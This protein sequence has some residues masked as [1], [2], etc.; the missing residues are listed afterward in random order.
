RITG[1][2]RRRPVSATPFTPLVVPDW[3]DDPDQVLSALAGHT[4][5]EPSA[6]D[7]AGSE[8]VDA[9]IA[10]IGG[11]FIDR[12]LL[13]R[14]L[15]KF[16]EDFDSYLR[17]HFTACT[18]SQRLAESRPR[19]AADTG[20][21]AH[22]AL[23]G[24]ASRQAL[25]GPGSLSVFG[26]GLSMLIRV[27]AAEATTVDFREMRIMAPV[28]GDDRNDLTGG[29]EAIALAEVAEAVESILLSPELFAVCNEIGP[30]V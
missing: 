13:D 26:A 16:D 11:W 5:D 28:A 30:R 3:V 27:A 10:A 22:L 2:V 4:A 17:G 24:V 1:V 25:P 19:A 8:P 20:H 6:V 9:V 12:P 23:N 18:I 15:D 29:V 7:A 21:V 14:G